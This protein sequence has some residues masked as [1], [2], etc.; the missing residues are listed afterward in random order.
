MTINPN[1]RNVAIV[2]VLAALV[3]FLPGGGTGAG[4]VIQ[5][6]S[7]AFLASLVWVGSILYRQNRTALYS[8]G[9]R[10]R[11]ALYA[12]AAVLAV[13]LSATPQLWA[14]SGGSV[15]WLVL[16]GASIYVGVAVFLA[17]RKY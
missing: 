16:V 2:L 13:T 6:L 17:A 7:L 11:T 15:A 14:T 5:A 3:A 10:H 4:V 9:N 12:A 8:L 1:V